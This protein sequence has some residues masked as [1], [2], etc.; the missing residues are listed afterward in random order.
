G[1]DL[2]LTFATDTELANAITA[3]ETLDNDTDDTN[4]LSDVQLNS[5]TIELTNPA[6]GATGVD[7]DLTF[8]T[9]TELANAIT[10]SETLDN[11]TDDTNELSDVQLN[12]TTLE[13]TNPA[14]GATGVD[15]DL[16]FAT[17]TELAN[18]ITASET[19]DNDTDDTNELSDI[20]L[21]STTLELTN[22]A[23]GATGVDLDLTFATDT[24]LANAITASETLDNDT[25]DTNELSDLSLTGT[26]LE[27]TNA[28]MGAIGANLASLD[29][30]VSAGEG[31]TITPTDQDFNVAVT[32]PVVSMGKIN[33]NGSAAKI[34]GAS[35]IQNSTGNYTVTFG[36]PRGDANYIIQLTLFGA[37]SGSTIQVTAQDVN[38]FTVQILEPLVNAP[39]IS[40]SVTVDLGGT[41]DPHTHNASIAAFPST[42]ITFSAAD[43][44]WY[45]TITD[46]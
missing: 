23:A 38:G 37:T 28:Q 21:N 2:D 5:T 36:S 40:P 24:E 22:P 3:S 41:S 46:F 19:L 18:A 15:L 6:A 43:A 29:E 42:D 8:A 4:E 14:A 35:V 39:L 7:L 11:D 25:D 33:A 20:Q 27:L 31:I 1:V 10:A 9:D 12:S 16:T 30:T 13:L 44:I 45:F 26:L 34:T 17:D 32:N